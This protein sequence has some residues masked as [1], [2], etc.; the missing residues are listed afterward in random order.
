MSSLFVAICRADGIPARLVRVPGHCYPEFYLLDRD[1]KGRWFPCQAAGTRAFG[2]MPDP[3]PILQ[4][5]DNSACLGARREEKD[6]G[7]VS[8][9]NAD[10]DPL[11]RRGC[12]EAQID[13]RASEGGVRKGR[14][15]KWEKR[16]EGIKP[17][18]R[19]HIVYLSLIFSLFPI[20]PFSLSYTCEYGIRFAR[21]K[22][23]C[24]GLSVVIRADVSRDPVVAG[25]GQFQDAAADPKGPRLGEAAP[26]AGRRG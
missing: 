19:S 20:F 17:F 8:P 15:E 7:P 23:C 10:R 11:R 18:R 2:G 3:R 16:V 21:S 5:G 22:R 25:L 24:R 26:C 4:K 9:G 6:Q 1:G 12:A 13:L 14:G